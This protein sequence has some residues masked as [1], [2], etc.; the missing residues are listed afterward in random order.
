MWRLGAQIWNEE[1]ASSQNKTPEYLKEVPLPAVLSSWAT[2]YLNR[3][4]QIKH[5]IDVLLVIWSPES[6]LETILAEN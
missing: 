2:S 1:K 6:N 5:N 3:I 4:K